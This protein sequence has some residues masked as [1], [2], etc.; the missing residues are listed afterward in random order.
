M[1]RRQ[2]IS[3][4]SVLLGGS[5]IGTEFFLSGC[6]PAGKKTAAGFSDEDIA[7]LDEIGEVIIPT[8]ASSPG[9]RSAAIG[10]FMKTI[11]NDCYT[12]NQQKVFTEGIGKL[13]EAC[14]AKYKKDFNSL[15]AAEKTDFLT[16]LDKEAKE[17][18]QTD[19]YKKKKEAFDKQQNEWVITAE[20]K[21]DFGASHI[22]EQY[23]PH[24]FTLIKQL[25]IWGYFTSEVGMTKALRYVEVPGKFDGAYPYQ[26]GERAWA[27][28]GFFG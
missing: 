27:I 17:Y 9:A 8:T 24:Y 13:K 26:K 15:Q 23:P 2:A 21:A 3:I 12:D 10:R 22:R 14:E 28:G 19:D 1:N 4:V 20:A 7:L 5:V 18:A 11:V 25:T 6:K 16:A